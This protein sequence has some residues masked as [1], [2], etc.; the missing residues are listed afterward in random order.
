MRL[1]LD[2][3]DWTYLA[4]AWVLA[5]NPSIVPVI[6]DRTRAQLIESTPPLGRQVTDD[7]DKATLFLLDEGHQPLPLRPGS[8]FTPSCE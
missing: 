4:I 1:R 2:L 5:K 3:L 8:C 6:G 7:Q